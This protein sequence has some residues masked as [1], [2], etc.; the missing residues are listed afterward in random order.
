MQ[1]GTLTR[2]W[3]EIGCMGDRLVDSRCCGATDRSRR[4]LPRAGALDPSVDFGRYREAACKRFIAMARTMGHHVYHDLDELAKDFYDDF[5]TEWLERPRRELSGPAVPYIAGAMMNKLRDL[6]RRGRSVRAPDL[7][8]SENE[9]IL[10]TIAAED[11]EPAEQVVLQE[12][13]WLV[14]EIVHT[15]PE[16]E[17]VAFAAVFGRDSRKKGTPPGGYKLAAAQLG[18]S[19]I[20]AKK[21]S[22]AAN[23]R[24]RAAVQKIEAGSWC[25]R[26]ASSIETVATGGQGDPAFL[27]HVEHCA[28]CRLG[29]VHLRRQAAI[30]PA[31]VLAAGSEHIGWMHRAF[32]PSR[33]TLRGLRDDLA[34]LFGRHAAAAND[35]S[36]G[37]LVGASGGA[38]GAGITAIKVGAICFGVGLTGSACL[39]AVGVP[40]PILAAVS[41]GHHHAHKHHPTGSATTRLA[42]AHITARII[43]PITTIPSHPTASPSVSRSRPAAHPAASRRSHASQSPSSEAQTELQPGGGSGGQIPV[44]G[45]G[46]SASAD[47]ASAHTAR[48]GSS[49]SSTSTPTT[50]TPPSS[51]STSGSGTATTSGSSNAFSAP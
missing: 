21:L 37:G 38:A 44:G 11:L 1:G 19:E 49:T 31:P 4:G 36:G 8:R 51:S 29:I 23:K 5:W 47:T 50:Q 41:G 35:A 6:S 33:A 9:A 30:L 7:V 48:S 27:R 24:I 3:G 20:R 43:P 25:D 13:M 16:R 15:L 10:A 18:V 39:Q 26:W 12:A 17:Q 34:G 2:G 45:A 46:A 22:L 14:S 28:Q 42:T 40:S 32:E